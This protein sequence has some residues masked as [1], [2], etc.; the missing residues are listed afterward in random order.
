MRTKLPVPIQIFTIL[1]CCSLISCNDVDLANFNKE[2]QLNES[3]V[4]PIGYAEATVNEIVENAQPAEITIDGQDVIWTLRDSAFYSM[5]PIEPIDFTMN[6]STPFALTGV[7]GEFTAIYNGKIEFFNGSTNERID[8]AYITSLPIDLTIGGDLGGNTFSRIDVVFNFDPNKVRSSIDGSA[9]S[10]PLTFTHFGEMQPLNIKNI[11]VVNLGADASVGIPVE[12]K[13]KLVTQPSVTIPA[14]STISF[15]SNFGKFDYEIAYGSFEIAEN[16]VG[17][18]ETFDFDI[19][20]DQYLAFLDP[21]VKI[22]VISNAG[23]S[24]DFNIDYLRALRVNDDKTPDIS[25]TPVYAEFSNGTT[26]YSFIVDGTFVPHTWE[27]DSALFDKNN[28]KTDRLFA[29]SS[30]PN[31]IEYKYSVG[32]KTPR[33]NNSPMFITP[34]AQIKVYAKAQ[35]PFWLGENSRYVYKD[36]VDNVGDSIVSQLKKLEDEGLE[37]TNV[38]LLLKIINHLPIHSNVKIKY[39]DSNGAEVNLGDVINSVDVQM[40]QVDSNG[41][42]IT[43]S[44]QTISIKV[45]KENI[46]KLKTVKKIAFEMLFDGEKDGTFN[47]IYAHPD[48]FFRVNIGLGVQGNYKNNFGKG[49]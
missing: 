29:Q 15:T 14:N 17:I 46:D 21:K 12:I 28:G 41:S 32:L 3:L 9:V 34:D 35:I 33:K 6:I 39:L 11:K 4:L 26:N 47:K 8:S 2:I 22:Q 18:E 44:E 25:F 7:L 1:T 36:S 43:Q 10:I 19:D 45:I 48:D 40:P 42:V 16:T 27:Q 20:R 37:I 13:F 23:I 24:M 49:K 5:K 31:R 30:M 38:D